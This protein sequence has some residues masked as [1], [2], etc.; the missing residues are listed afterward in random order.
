MQAGDVGHAGDRRPVLFLNTPTAPPLGADTWIHA[1]I[2]RRLDR[3]A[4]APVAAHAFG[5]AGDPTPIHR[6]LVTIP[7]LELVRANLGPELTGQSTLG[8]LKR[9]VETVPALWTIVRLG[10][11]IKRRGIEVI[12]TSDRPRDAFVAVVLGRLTGARSIVHVHVGYDTS[13][14]GRM[15]QW[16]LTHADVLVAISDFV[17][18]TLVDGGI[19]P[20]RV[21]VVTNGI[22]VTR[23]HP[24]ADGA[25]ARRRLGI[26]PDAPLLITISRLFPEKGPADVIEAVARLRDELPGIQLLIIGSDVPGSTYSEDLRRLAADRGVSDHVAL[27]GRRDD[28]EELLAAAD[29]FVM[30]SFQEP[31]GLVFCEAMA[32]G[33]PVVALDDGGTVEIVE[34]GRTGLLSSRGD[35]DALTANLRSLLLDPARRAAMGATGR[36]VVAE[37]LTADR[38]AADV[39]EMYQALSSPDPVSERSGARGSSGMRVLEHTTDVDT[40]RRAL[41]EDGYIVIRDVVDRER[42]SELAADLMSEYERF[43]VSSEMFEGGGTLSGHLN[44][45]PGEQSRFVWDEITKA[46][47]PDLV[48]AVRPDIADSVRATLNFNLPGSVAQHYHTDGLYTKEFL[49]CNIAVVDTD[50]RNGALDVLPGTNREFYK[51]WRYAAHRLWRKSTRVPVRQGDVIVRKSTQWHRGMPNYSDTPRPMMA[52]TFGEMDDLDQDPFAMNDGKPFFYANWYRTN[53]L[54]KLRE[55]IFVKAPITYSA[56]RFARSLYGNKG[57]SSF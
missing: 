48:R 35:L 5:P 28:V 22:D 7:D 38:M 17:G 54:G 32:M 11:L 47:I 19:D 36:H 26:D 37:R 34:D 6:V 52:I 43:S 39:S 23:W 4:W 18:R 29:V 2:M 15:L 30:P 41:D 12:H 14:M 42:L 9:L 20:A 40:F 21:H 51:F 56:W 57:Y 24:D 53:R 31:F 46:G 49:I 27:L 1:E 45:F 8:K 25:A 44:C 50:L 10:V 13:W 33:K 3:T 55:Q 16:S